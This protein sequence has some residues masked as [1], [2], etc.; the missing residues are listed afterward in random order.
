VNFLDFLEGELGSIRARGLRRE[1][2]VLVGPHAARAVVDGKPCALFNSN[3]YLG[4]AT[5]PRVVRAAARALEEWGFGAP[6]SRLIAGTTRIHRELEARLA[7]FKREEDAVVFPAGYM[8]NLGVLQSLAAKDDLVVSDEFNHASL[9]D[10]CRLSRAEVR[11][12]RHG[13]PDAAR[14]ELRG[15]ARGRRAFLVTDAVFSMDGDAAPL[16][17]LRRAADEAGAWLVVDEAHATGVLGRTG[18]GIREHFG[19]NV[20]VEVS[21]GTLGKALGGMGGFVAGPAALAELVRNRARTFFYTTAPIPALCAGV[22]EALSILEE[23]PGRVDALRAN[24]ALMR[25][26]LR[27]GGATVPDHPSAIVPLHVGEA[28]RALEAANRLFERGYF[29]SAIRPPT[30]PEGTSRLRVSVTAAHA[31]GEIRG[32]A[33]AVG[34]ILGENAKDAEGREGS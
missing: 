12:Y 24:A 10:G 9:V 22:L 15:L 3:D 11:V 20:P 16:P 25:E 31:E 4:M 17:D 6:S 34:E 19:W 1:P 28:G 32:F 26:R 33:A 7:A 2:R 5:H 14:R 21:I 18:R 13:D 27:R 30:V 29:V 23:E 8:A